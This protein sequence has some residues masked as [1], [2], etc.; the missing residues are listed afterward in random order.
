MKEKAE[1]VF[2]NY[3]GKEKTKDIFERCQFEFN[4]NFYLDGFKVMKE[5]DETDIL[6]TL[7]KISNG[8]F[9]NFM[10]LQ[11]V[12]RNPKVVGFNT[13]VIGYDGSV[14]FT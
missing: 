4:G 1:L 2:I 6:T 3:L 9:D 5:L 13:T 11:E 10:F 12:V 7:N 8:D 14:T